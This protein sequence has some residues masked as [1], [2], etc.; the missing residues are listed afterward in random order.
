MYIFKD[1]RDHSCLNKALQLSVRVDTGLV[2]E[3]VVSN[4]FAKRYFRE[5]HARLC[6]SVPTFSK[7]TAVAAQ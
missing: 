3:P 2:Q 5:C 6:K 4:L 7:S 1:S